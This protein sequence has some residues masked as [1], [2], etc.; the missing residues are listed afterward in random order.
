MKNNWP[1]AKSE[2]IIVGAIFIAG[3]SFLFIKEQYGYGVVLLLALF[4]LLKLDNLLELAFGGF[5]AKFKTPPEKIEEEIRENKQQ[6]S[7]KNFVHFQNIESQIL[8]T[9]QKRYGGE[10][11]TL[12]HFLYGRPDKPE[13]KYTPDGSLMTNDAL[14]FFEV[15]YVLKP[16]L[17]KN[18]VDK[19]ITYLKEVYSKLS[20]SIGDKKFVIKIIL[21]SG[22]DLSGI[23]FNTPEGIEIEFFK[24]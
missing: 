18:I 17:A 7:N 4:P 15:K 24:V 13:F 21:A 8:S 2:Q 23:H 16:E 5:N 19:T 10:M 20:P 1:V 14:Y 9:L 11:K 12:V 3:C 22:Y 6:V